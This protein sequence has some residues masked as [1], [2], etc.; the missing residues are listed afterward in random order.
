MS[1]HN[2]IIYFNNCRGRD[3]LANYSRHGVQ[4]CFY[5]LYQR[6]VQASQATD[7]KPGQECVVATVTKVSRSTLPLPD[8][9]VRFDR[10]VFRLERR[11]ADLKGDDCRLFCGDHI[12][13]IATHLQAIA[14]RHFPMFFNKLG[15]FLERSTIEAVP[16][17]QER[18]ETL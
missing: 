11:L 4:D 2:P 16:D 3:F 13:T 8:R 10:Y 5:D 1:Q 9:P 17:E 6:G 18:A 12:E 15:H 14:P 7:L